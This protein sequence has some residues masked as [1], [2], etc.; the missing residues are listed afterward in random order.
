[1]NYGFFVYLALA[2]H[3]FLAGATD[4]EREPLWKPRAENI[5]GGILLC[6]Y[7]ALST[8][9]GVIAFADSRHEI[10][11]A[12]QPLRRF[13]PPFRVINTYHLFG[14]I[15]RE[16]I[17]PDFQTSVDGETFVGHDFPFK[18]GDPERRPPF[19]AP[20]QPRVDFL[21]WFYGLSYRQ[22]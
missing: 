15:T 22:G 13:H 11:R 18:P 6:L 10:A 4:Y 21:L 2:L 12:V 16:R 1:A 5:A 7:G 14:S 17:E 3:V 9:E 19:V 8:L 20:H